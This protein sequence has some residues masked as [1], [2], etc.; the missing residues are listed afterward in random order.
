[1]TKDIDPQ[2]KDFFRKEVE[3]RREPELHYR[4]SFTKG[5]LVMVISRSLFAAASIL[6]FCVTAILRPEKP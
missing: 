1:M 6:I 5:P 2:L 4:N 3:Q